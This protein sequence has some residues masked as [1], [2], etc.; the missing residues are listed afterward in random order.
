MSTHTMEQVLFD[1]ASAPAVAAEFQR[2]RRAFL[3]AYR[4]TDAEVELVCA[5]DV[6]NMQQLGVDPMLTMRA[7]TAVEGRERL[8]D[9][10]ASL[11]AAR[12]KGEG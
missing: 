11:H 5:F 7:Y 10:M 3:Q 12:A 6:A 1:I 9:Y 4:L 8:G 2:D